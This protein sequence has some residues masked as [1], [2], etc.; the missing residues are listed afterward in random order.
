MSAQGIRAGRAFVE[1]GTNLG[2]LSRGLKQAQA[3][4]GSL[5]TYTANIG[6]RL[7]AASA[8][9]GAPIAMAVRHFAASGDQ[10]SKASDKTGMAVEAL[11]ELRHAAGQSAVSFSD[12]ETSIARQQKTM[13]EAMNGSQAAIDKFD[14]LGLSIDHLKD[15]SPDM[16][17][18][19]IAAAISDIPDDAQRATAAMEIFGRSGANLL[20]LMRSDIA[21]LRKEARDLGLQVSTQDAAN[22]TKLGDAWSLVGSVVKSVQF[23]LGS[24]LAP[25]LITVANIVTPAIKLVADFVSK[26]RT[27]VT[28]VAAVV[29]AVAGVGA[30]LIAFSVALLAVK[31][32]IGAVLGLFA[33]AKIAL[34]V[35][36]SPAVLLAA[37]IGFLA[38]QLV[39]FQKVGETVFSWFMEKFG[40]LVAEFQE[41]VGAIGA[42]LTRGDIEAAA[43]ILW[44]GLKSAWLSGTVNLRRIWNDFKFGAISVFFEIEAAARRMWASITSAAQKGWTQWSV[45]V[46]KATNLAMAEIQKLDVAESEVEERARIDR[47]TAAVNSA[48][49]GQASQAISDI[50]NQLRRDQQTIEADRQRIQNAISDEYEKSVAAITSDI[51]SARQA[52]R[53]LLNEEKIKNKEA[54]EETKKRAEENTRSAA[55]ASISGMDSTKSNREVAG[56]F[57]AFGLFG[58]GA[59]SAAERTAQNTDK[60]AS[61]SVEI[62]RNTGLGMQFE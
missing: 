3:K 11:S 31:F 8:V 7:M 6:G 46:K 38:F 40:G 13:G 58:L 61:L 34:A 53:D 56:T 54:A 30:G 45:M 47:E 39:D 18:E 1:I 16:Q 42:A 37:A 62:A 2:P 24:A 48:L 4:L 52:Y 23:A 9:I 57:S 22:A 25:A 59:S 50:D 19:A 35:M 28:I 5:A 32:A 20:P 27:L 43:N 41:F 29:V 44:L 33:A 26:N 60:I 10:L 51:E 12:F 17:F 21:G 36:L 15:L 55:S 14:R 49:D